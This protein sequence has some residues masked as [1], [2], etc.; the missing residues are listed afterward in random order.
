MS[1]KPVVPAWLG[2]SNWWVLVVV[3]L[4]FLLFGGV[5]TAG[6][7]NTASDG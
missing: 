6:E 7:K 3:V 5:F 2:G 1:E 4:F